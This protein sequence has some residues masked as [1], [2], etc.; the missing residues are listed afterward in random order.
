[1]N[2]PPSF[3]VVIAT[4]NR[5]RYVLETVRSVAE[6][7]LPAHQIIVVVDGS[8]DG[9]AE[10]LR[11]EFCGVTV[12]EQKNLGRSVARNSGIALATGDW[13]CF[14]DDD[15]LWRREKLERT[16][17]YLAECP[18]CEAVTNPVWFFS[19][20]ED[21]PAGGFGF[22]RDFVAR[23]LEEC[24]A[25]SEAR[26]ASENSADYL[27]IQ[28]DSFRLL[29]ERNRGVMSASVVKRATLIRAGCF[30]PMH[31]YA[32]DW[33]M[34]VNVARLCEWHTLPQRLGFTR[35]HGA[36]SPND[37]NA[38]IIAAAQINAWFGGRPLPRR[39][40]HAETLRELTA[41]SAAYRHSIQQGYWTALRS[42]EF[43]VARLILAAGQMLLP[44]FIDR[45][46]IRL[47]PQLTW[48]WEHH[49][50]GLHK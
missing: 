39:T 32:D 41:Y 10:A 28:G 30:C 45:L 48:R 14:L 18:E 35:L 43:G 17:A 31:D 50:L 19:D 16:A 13:V 24:H 36:Q 22:R 7:T 46:I 4:Y 49:I 25:A 27:Q 44:R 33:T 47:P 29:L 21:G 8:E 42:R 40:R 9:T 15:D 34:F 20:T 1:M 23:D 5:K 38:L 11:R 37:T 6:Q 3:S 12:F 2:V 26:P